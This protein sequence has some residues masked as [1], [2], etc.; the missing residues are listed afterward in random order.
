MSARFRS[1]RGKFNRLNESFVDMVTGHMAMD[2]ERGLKQ[3]AGMPVKTGGM[4][5]ATRSFRN[6]RGKHR[7]EIN[8]V[9]AA[10]QEAGIRMTGKGAPTARFKNYTTTGTSA[11]FFQ[12]AIDSVIRNKNNYFEEAR[13]ALGL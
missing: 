6:R 9:Y 3:S 7:V 11:G 8:K 1:T 12:R 4:K 2:I 13:R 5:A 10:T